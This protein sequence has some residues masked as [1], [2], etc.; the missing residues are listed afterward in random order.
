MIMWYLIGSGYMALTLFR[1][2]VDHGIEPK[3][4]EQ[5][6]TV[7]TII[8]NAEAAG[9][10]HAYTNEKGVR[11]YDSGEFEAFLKTLKR[12]T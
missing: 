4:A 11:V 1:Y 2:L 5:I 8:R 9:F 3:R 12:V 10:L 7:E 6:A